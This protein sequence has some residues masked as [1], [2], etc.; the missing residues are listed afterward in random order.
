M[1]MDGKTRRTI[2]GRI[3]GLLLGCVLLAA[4]LLSA[5][6][7]VYGQEYHYNYGSGQIKYGP[8]AYTFSTHGRTEDSFRFSIGDG[9][10]TIE[11]VP[12]ADDAKT[13]SFDIRRRARWIGSWENNDVEEE[14]YH[15]NVQNY[16]S[17][18]GV[19]GDISL[20]YSVPLPR[21]DGIYSLSAGVSGIG[22]DN[23]SSGVNLVFTVDGSDAFFRLTGDYE[24]NEKV[25][26]ERYTSQTALWAFTKPRDYKEGSAAEKKVRQTAEKIVNKGDSDYEKIKKVNNWVAENVWYDLNLAAD[27]KSGKAA[28]SHT[29]AVDVLKSKRAVCDGYAN[30]TNELLHALGIPSRWVSGWAADESHAWNEAYADGRWIILDST[31]DSENRYKNGKFSEKGT[32]KKSGQYFDLSLETFMESHHYYAL[33]YR[34]KDEY[35]AEDDGGYQILKGELKKHL[36]GPEKSLALKKGKTKQLSVKADDAGIRLKDFEITYSTDNKKVVSVSNKGKIKANQAGSATIQ[37]KVRL[38]DGG[39]KIVFTYKTKVNVT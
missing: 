30:L 4:G 20:P 23:S 11:S 29:K 19:L 15:G 22:P 39:R 10:I 28:S 31:W 5:V 9:C 1:R 14:G 13:I 18:N 2:G 37:T 38:K 34:D 26:R 27:V 35:Y 24:E 16:Y 17:L 32:G 36:S 12:H 6:Q 25:F 7:P 8:K 3:L 33:R 21:E